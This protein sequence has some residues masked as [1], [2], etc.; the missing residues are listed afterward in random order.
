VPSP[1][2][3]VRTETARE[4]GRGPGRVLAGPVV[5]TGASGQVGHAL[6][7]RLAGLAVPT[8][9]LVEHSTWVHA[10]RVLAGPLVSPPTARALKEAGTIVHLAGTL[11]PMAPN[12]YEA[13]NLRTT[14]AVAHALRHGDA[15]RVLFLSYVGADERSPNLYL[16]LKARAERLL[17]STGKEVV[18]F[19]CTHII[20]PRWAPGPTASALLAGPKGRVT[21]LGNGRQ[22][23]APLN[24]DD[25]ADALVAALQGGPAGIYD[26]AGPDRMRLDDLVRRLNGED[27]RIR[28]L[29]ALLAR[30]LGHV[31]PSLSPPLV[32]VMLRDSI[33]DP[34]RAVEAFVLRLR[35]VEAVWG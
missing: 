20:G 1:T 19:R 18:V 4:V 6:L 35:P 25:V 32:D 3:D 30:L 29:P 5:V 27:V 26:L 14:E 17:A 12:T 16:R 7:A 10:S 34:A 24:V 15:R 9:G 22:V 21:V 28:H 13:A 33:G 31:L 23:I 11:R 8:V 2:L